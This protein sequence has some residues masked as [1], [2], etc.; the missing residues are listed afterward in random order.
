MYQTL[1]A[2]GWS[3]VL[4]NEVQAEHQQS[5]VTAKVPEAGIVIADDKI[6]WERLKLENPN[7]YW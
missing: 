3:T 7:K 4:L 6:E 2:H 5:A 1:T